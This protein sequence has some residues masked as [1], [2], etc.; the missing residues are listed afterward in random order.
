MG[1]FV[2]IQMVFVHTAITITLNYAK[3]RLLCLDKVSSS[4]FIRIYLVSRI[5]TG[6]VL[7]NTKEDEILET[8]ASQF[9]NWLTTL[10]FATFKDSSGYNIVD[11]ESLLSVF[12]QN[13]NNIVSSTTTIL[14]RRKFGPNGENSSSDKLND[15]RQA[16]NKT[17]KPRLNLA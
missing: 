7:Q 8:L 2:I 14:G 3:W 5:A 15:E 17:Q 9:L 10:Y 4:D 1:G 11:K 12:Y 16:T 6:D 13:Y